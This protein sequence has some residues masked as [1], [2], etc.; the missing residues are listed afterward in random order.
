MNEPPDPIS[1]TLVA[2]EPNFKIECNS[3]LG[4]V[5][6]TSRQFWSPEVSRGFLDLLMLTVENIR[7]ASGKARIL[8]N[9]LE[10]SVQSSDSTEMFTASNTS[11]HKQEDYI[12]LVASSVL[13]KLQFTRCLNIGELNS[14]GTEAEALD[15]LLART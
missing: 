15:W 4:L 10:C 13:V 9:A 3:I 12:A 11:M 8:I 1:W 2:D 5:R 7:K 14:F 6:V